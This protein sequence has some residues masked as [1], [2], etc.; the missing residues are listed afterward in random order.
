MHNRL[1]A[2][3]RAMQQAGTAG[4]ERKNSGCPRAFTN[5]KTTIPIELGAVFGVHIPTPEQQAQ[6]KEKERIAEMHRGVKAQKE[7][8]DKW[9][10]RQLQAATKKQSVS[11]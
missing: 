4:T 5:K 11:N 10:K 1:S 7:A 6:T 8:R 9:T 2:N 3:L